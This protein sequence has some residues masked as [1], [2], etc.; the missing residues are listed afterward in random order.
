[1]PDNEMRDEFVKLTSQ[2]VDNVVRPVAQELEAE[3]EYPETLIKEMKE[4]GMFGMLIPEQYGGLG[5][6]LGTYWRVTSEISRGWMSLGGAINSHTITGYLIDRFGTEEQKAKYL[7]RMAT[8]DLRAALAMTEVEAGTDVAAIRTVAVRTEDGYRINGTKMFITNGE[9]AGLVCLLAKTDPGAEKPHKG[10]SLLLVEKGPGLETGQKIQKL[11][12]N[13][14]ETVPLMFD[15]MPVPADSVLGEEPGRGFYQAMTGGEVGR[16]NGGAR[17]HGV[18]RA[19]IDEAT[20]YALD[21]KTFGVPIAEHQAIQLHIAEM[22][23]KTH[24]AAGLLDMA[25]EK[26]EAGGRADLEAGMAK[27][28]A[29]EVAVEV[30]MTSMRI[31][32]GYGYTKEFIVE[33]LFRDAPQMVIAEGTNEIQKIIIAKSHF[34]RARA[35]GA[36]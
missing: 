10:M 14:I 35:G 33:R 19:A 16:L 25:A 34:A 30:T 11:G 31:H 28:Y 9:R 20:R 22:L 18:A 4:M 29:T 13:G 12:Y 36:G 6:D 26:L 15:N 24:A 27:Y 2:W 7:P 21:R 5:V 1:M 17:A 32:G 3:N 8:G 23:T